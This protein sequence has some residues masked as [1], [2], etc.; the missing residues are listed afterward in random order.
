MARRF[1]F[2]SPKWCCFETIDLGW[3]REVDIPRD[4]TETRRDDQY[5][6]DETKVLI[7]LVRL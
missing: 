4:K 7:G 2:Y 6:P 3:V 5:L 1:R